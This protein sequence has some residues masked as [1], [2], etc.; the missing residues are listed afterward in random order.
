L[1]GKIA[2][3]K[4]AR[5]AREAMCR[6]CGRC[7]HQKLNVDGRIFYLDAACPH[8]DPE[9][10]LC[11]VYDRRFEVNPDCISVEEGIRRGVFPADCPYVAGLAGYRPP[12]EDPDPE[13]LADALD[14]L[15][16]EEVEL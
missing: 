4:E 12:M 14:A 11:R 15:V 7:C 3:E 1:G 13:S 10:R 9:T 2:S 16:G 5:R 8:L 6:R